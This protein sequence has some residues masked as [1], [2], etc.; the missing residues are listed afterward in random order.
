VPWTVKRFVEG[1]GRHIYKHT[2]RDA[3]ARIDRVGA[4][5]SAN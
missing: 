4:V 5:P 3:L 2:W 1:S